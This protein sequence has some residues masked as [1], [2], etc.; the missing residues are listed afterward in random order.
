[1]L[2]AFFY[3]RVTA[4][5]IERLAVVLKQSNSLENESRSRLG[6]IQETVQGG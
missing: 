1:M 5:L 2:G 4:S 6:L 3:S